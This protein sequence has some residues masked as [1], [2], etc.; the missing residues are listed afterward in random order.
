MCV[1]LTVT[2]PENRDDVQTHKGF[3]PL[4][5]DFSR[6]YTARIPIET[7]SCNSVR[8]SIM[9]ILGYRTKTTDIDPRTKLR[10]R[11]LKYFKMTR[12]FSIVGT[13]NKY[14]VMSVRRLRHKD[15]SGGV[16]LEPHV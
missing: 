14:Q 5:K 3:K 12:S 1:S 11:I 4:N 8:Q 16:I 13:T 6:L 10:T 15:K 7:L 9:M 2:T